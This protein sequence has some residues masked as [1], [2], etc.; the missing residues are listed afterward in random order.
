MEKL[1]RRLKALR[2][3]EF[4]SIIFDVVPDVGEID[5]V[6]DESMEVNES[7]RELLNEALTNFEGMGELDIKTEIM[8][9]IEE[10]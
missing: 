8:I 7:D 5:T 1:V 2:L 4:A 3:A 9:T 6:I 10:L